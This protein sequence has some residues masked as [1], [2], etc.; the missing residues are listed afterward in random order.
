MPVSPITT[1]TGLLWP[2][3]VQVAGVS[4]LA[5]ALFCRS[6]GVG[7]AG[8]T[9]E[10]PTGIHDG[11]TRAGTRRIVDQLPD[12]ILPV[13]ITYLHTA[14]E[15]V[16]LV[17]ETSVRAIQFHG[18]VEVSEVDRFREACPDVKT[19][20]RITTDANVACWRIEAGEVLRDNRY[21]TDAA[22]QV[23]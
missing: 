3:R 9:L 14:D 12:D 4:S 18:D 15:A 21:T 13:V 20:G 17:R 1:E 10:L 2:P 22:F 7:A 5:E 23:K 6:V 19:I 16:R 8:F 11:L